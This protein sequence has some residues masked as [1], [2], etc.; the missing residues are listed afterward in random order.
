MFGT[1]FIQMLE[2]RFSHEEYV[3]DYAL[4]KQALE[5][6]LG[7]KNELT[8]T[9]LFGFPV[10]GPIN[11]NLFSNHLPGTA[12][13]TMELIEPDGS[14]PIPNRLGTYELAAFTKLEAENNDD[15]ERPFGK[16]VL[17]LR[18]ILSIIGRHSFTRLLNPLNTFEILND[19]GENTLLIFDDYKEFT[20][21]ERKHHLLVCVEIFRSELNYARTEGNHWLIQKLKAAGHYP[22]SDLD[23]EPV[24]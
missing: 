13:V 2:R 16:M 22:Y 17:H 14:G 4:K 15:Y 21:G 1:Y 19:E 3:N 24:V 6:I 10:G 9:S 7:E 11:L 18:E 8:I 23:R 5:A 20:I 12:F